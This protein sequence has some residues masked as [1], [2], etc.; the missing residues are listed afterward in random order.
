MQ[1]EGRSA[2]E[3]A[4]TVSGSVWLMELAAAVLTI[5]AL[6]CAAGQIWERM[7]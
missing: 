5:I 2:A 6:V 4:A 3:L 1:N 7:L